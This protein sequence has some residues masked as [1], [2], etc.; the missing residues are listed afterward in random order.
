MILLNNEITGVGE[1]V[2]LAAY[3]VCV[4]EIVVN[5]VDDYACQTTVLLDAMKQE[6]NALELI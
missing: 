1:N 3:N 6:N 4:N 5:H 2:Q